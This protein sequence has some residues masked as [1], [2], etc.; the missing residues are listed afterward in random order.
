[1]YQRPILQEI[2]KRMNEYRKFIQVLVGP[3]QVGKTTL[4]KQL[5]QETNILNH[6]VTADDMYTTDSTWIKREW[7]NVRLKMRQGNRT[8]ALII[9]DEIQKAPN[10]SEAVKKEWD[11]DSFQT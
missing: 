5:L 9:I 1:M 4:I 11:S 8:E 10:W 6:F 7:D 2:K 3:R